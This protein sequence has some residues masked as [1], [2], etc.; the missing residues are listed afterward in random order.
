MPFNSYTGKISHFNFFSNRIHS[1]KTT[2]LYSR[3]L[4]ICRY[5]AA[6]DF[7][8]YKE[9]KAYK[10]VDVPVY[11]CKNAFLLNMAV[12]CSEI[13]LKSSWM[14]VE[15]PAQGIMM[16]QWRNCTTSFLARLT[17]FPLNPWLTQA[18]TCH[19]IFEQHIFVSWK[20][21]PHNQGCG[22]GQF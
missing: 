7:A 15:F 11:Q 19:R 6:P 10:Y 13:R 3:Y 1:S 17:T 8:M 12:N 4:Y 16:C 18:P 22:S 2:V 20:R 9:I 14:A 21:D 5:W